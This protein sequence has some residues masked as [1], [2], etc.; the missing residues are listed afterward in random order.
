MTQAQL[1][2]AVAQL[3]D[4]ALSTIGHRGFSIVEMPNV[5]DFD[6]STTRQVVN[7]DAMDEARTRLLPRRDR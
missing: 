2:R 6:S 3:T 4:E 5:Y 7:R 1:D